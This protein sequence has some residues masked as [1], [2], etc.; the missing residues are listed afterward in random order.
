MNIG[1]ER[2]VAAR[3]RRRLTSAP[4]SNLPL[5]GVAIFTF[6]L[7]TSRWSNLFTELGIWLALIG[8]LLRPQDLSFPTP[9]RWAAAFLV[10][11]SV[12]AV[13]AIS[14]GTAGDA[15]IERLK[16]LVIFFVVVNVLRTPQQLRFFMLL[17]L[18][19]FLIYPAR[20]SLMNYLHGETLLGRAIW[21][22]VYANPNDLAAITLLMLGLALA[23]GTVK[24]QNK[25]LRRAV[26]AYV[27]V[28]LVIILLTQ[29]RG[30]LIGLMVGFGP[31]VLKRIRQRP[32]FIVPVLIGMVVL[33]ALIP[34]ASW[35]R[36]ENMT[37]L[38]S[39]DTLAEA[40]KYGSALQR[41]EILKVGWHI[42][43]DHPVLGVGIGCYNEANARYAPELGKR[44]VHNTYLSLAA[45]MGLPGLLLWL[46]LAG[47]VLA[48]VR[49]RRR[50]LEA[51]VSTIETL[52]LE[53]AVIGYLVAGLFG[54]YYALTMFYLLLGTLWAAAN[55]LGADAVQPGAVAP[56]RRPMRAR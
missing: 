27:P 22:K 3:T 51:N 17:M 7:V 33:A 8:M 26:I 21:N 40:D 14:P 28:L 44:D 20:G 53:R 12:S 19:A 16:A 39:V 35:H 36:F 25:W 41:F 34:G 2:I 23:I 13:F 10:W 1:T 29:S 52:W 49:R 32:T 50:S 55:V 43:T 31:T 6:F 37:K 4:A 46:G 56:A 54:T 38:T 18:A 30:G 9:V 5:V 42:F 24:T 47:S 45:E 15:L 11:V 48:Q